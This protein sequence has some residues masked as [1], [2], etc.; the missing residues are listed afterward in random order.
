MAICVFET[1]RWGSD[2]GSLLA[3]AKAREPTYRRRDRPPNR[4]EPFG[5]GYDR[6]RVV[7]A[8]LAFALNDTP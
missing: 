6:V 2:A 3:R 5:H 4:L 7:N 1:R 8:D